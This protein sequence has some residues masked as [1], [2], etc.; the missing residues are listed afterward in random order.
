MVLV[1]VVQHVPA[2]HVYTLQFADV[3]V[4]HQFHHL[5]I[6]GFGTV[7]GTE[8][9][10]PFV[11]IDC[12]AKQF[13]LFQVQ[14]EGLLAIHVLTGTRCSNRHRGMPVVMSADKDGIH[15]GMGNDLAEIIVNL[16]GVLGIIMLVHF[17][18]QGYPTRLVGVSHGD[19][20]C[21]RIL[22]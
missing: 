15:I 12:R 4:A 2:P 22:L 21:V 20:P 10:N 19:N 17:F 5:R 16:C 1:G 6:K 11:V 8:L 13:R 7:L 9:E 18:R 14:R 3:A